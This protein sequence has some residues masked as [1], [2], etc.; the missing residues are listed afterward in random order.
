MNEST[1]HNSRAGSAELKASWPLALFQI[2]ESTRENDDT[3]S[4]ILWCRNTRSFDEYCIA[5]VNYLEAFLP[6]G[7]V[8]YRTRPHLLR[9]GLNIQHLG[10]TCSSC[11]MIFSHRVHD[12][13]TRRT[14]CDPRPTYFSGSPYP[15]GGRVDFLLKRLSGYLMCSKKLSGS[16]NHYLKISKSGKTGKNNPQRH[17]VWSSLHNRSRMGA[18]K[19]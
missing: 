16:G 3:C 14:V 4:S 17:P 5:C 2:T 1:T 19:L 12:I 11:W 18:V 7:P 9:P 8:H 15:R 10:G 13:K 6:L